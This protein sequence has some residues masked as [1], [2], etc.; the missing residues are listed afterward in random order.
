MAS[1]VLTVADLALVSDPENTRV[2]LTN[3]DEQTPTWEAAQALVQFDGYTDP[4]LYRGERVTATWGL[5]VSFAPSD[6]E[7]CY[8]LLALL[9]TAHSATD[10]RL[11]LRTI[12]SSVA[13]LD[14]V[15]VVAVPSWTPRRIEG[16]AWQ[17]DMTAH[18]V[19][20]TAEV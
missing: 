9:Q 11:Q 6:H 1:L 19:A 5:S 8:Q 15:Q 10:G 4:T 17:V 7:G 12:G 2:E 16:G 3:V 18:R 13:G 14:D 20:W